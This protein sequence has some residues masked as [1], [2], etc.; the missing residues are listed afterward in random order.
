VRGVVVQRW[1]P[2]LVQPWLRCVFVALTQERISWIKIVVAKDTT[3]QV[4][5]HTLDKFS[6][7]ILFTSMFRIAFV[8]FV[9]LTLVTPREHH[10]RLNRWFLPW[11][12][13][14]V[15]WLVCLVLFF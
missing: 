12:T 4:R 15:G 14:A 10:R 2:T 7:Q 6:T 5:E 3:F 9:I 13:C 1:E 11:V 8:G